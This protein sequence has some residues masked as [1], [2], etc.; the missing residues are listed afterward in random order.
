MIVGDASATSLPR[1][2]HDTP[3]VSSYGRNTVTIGTTSNYA[4]VEVYTTSQSI[5]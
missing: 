3:N 2:I 1:L 4:T 5:T